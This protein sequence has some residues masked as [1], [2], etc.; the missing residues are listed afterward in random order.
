[1]EQVREG[2]FH[3]ATTWLVGAYTCP[4]FG[5]MGEPFDDTLGG[6]SVFHRQEWLR[7]S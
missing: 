7:L 4:L 2:I 5:L 1:M 6:F 3:E